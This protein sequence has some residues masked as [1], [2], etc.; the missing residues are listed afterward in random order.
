MP[1]IVTIKI[2]NVYLIVKLYFNT[3][4]LIYLIDIL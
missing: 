3:K 2:Y 4:L 1:K